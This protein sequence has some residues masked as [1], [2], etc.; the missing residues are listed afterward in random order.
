MDP[1]IL[2]LSTSLSVV[3]ITPRSFFSLGKL[4][5][6]PLSRRPDGPK[7]WS[8]GHGK[9]ENSAPTGTRTLNLRLSSR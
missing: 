8:G 6:H 7:N 5:R 9:E 4:P 1:R 2:D 3:N